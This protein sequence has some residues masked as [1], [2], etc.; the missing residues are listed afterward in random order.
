[1]PTL[2]FTLFF[3][4]LLINPRQERAVPL[5]SSTQ[6]LTTTKTSEE[7]ASKVIFWITVI[8]AAAF[9]IRVILWLSLPMGLKIAIGIV[10]GFLACLA[11]LFA[12]TEGTATMIPVWHILNDLPL[13]R[14]RQTRPVMAMVIAVAIMAAYFALFCFLTWVPW[15]FIVASTSVFILLLPFASVVNSRWD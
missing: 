5:M 8:C 12:S 6:A 14:G 9:G 13:L 11:C 10:S 1:M 15:R 7:E 4:N 2:I 3:D